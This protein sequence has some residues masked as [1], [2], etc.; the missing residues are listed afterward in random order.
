[1]VWIGKV[2]F[3][4]F[5]DEGDMGEIFRGDRSKECFLLGWGGKERFIVL[6]RGKY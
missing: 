5:G 6:N 4:E 3:N 1:M 2:F